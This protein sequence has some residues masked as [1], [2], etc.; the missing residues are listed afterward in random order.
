MTD[1]DPLWYKD[2][3]IYQL[4]VRAFQDSR[5]DGVGD[6]PGLTQRLDYLQDLGVTAVWLLPFYPSPLRDDGYDIAD[7]MAVHPSYGNLPEFQTF[8]DAAHKRGLRVITELVINHTSDQHPWFQRA[9]QAP[10]GSP[11]RNFYVWSDTPDKYQNV[12]LMFPDF[13]TSNWQ[14]DPVAKQYYWHRFYSHQPDLNFDNPAVRAALFPVIDFWMGMGVDGMRLDAVPYLFEREGTLCEHLPET[15]AYL[16]SL[17]KYVDE[18]YPGRMFLAEANAWPED[19]VQ[20][21]GDGDECHMAFNFPL[22][23]R[24]YMALHQEDR[25]PILDVMEQTPPIPDVAQWCLFLRNHD[26]MTLAMI[27]DEERDSMFRAYARDGRAKIFQGIRHRLAPLLGNDRRRIELLTALL[28]S[29]QG[30]PVI[31]YGDEIGMG[32]NIYLGDRNGVRTPMQWSPDRNAGFSRANP[33]RL[34]LPIVIDPEYSYEAVNVETQQANA[35]SLLWWTKRLIALRK[36]Y[37]AFGRGSIEF[38]KPRNPKILAFVR[39]HEDE[40]ILVVANLSRFVQYVELDLKEFDGQV[41]TELTGRTPFPPVGD[42]P[43]LLTVGPHGILWFAVDPNVVR[44]PAVAGR[45]RAEPVPVVPVREGWA[46]LLDPTRLDWLARAVRGYLTETVVAYGQVRRVQDVTIRAAARV[47]IDDAT[48]FLL[49]D[50]AFL[51]GETQLRA[52]RLRYASPAEDDDIPAGAVVAE[53]TRG[54]ERAGLLYDGRTDPG[55]SEAILRGIADGR[56]FR[57]DGHQV[58]AEHFPRFAEVRGPDAVPGPITFRRGDQHDATALFGDRLVLKSYERLEP[59][60]HPAVEVGRF[61]AEHTPFRNTPPVVGAVELRPAEAAESTTMAVLFGHVSNEGTAWRHALDVLSRFYEAVLAHP[62]KPPA[63]APADAW[64][65]GVNYDPH[66]E[67]YDL[68]N[69]Y[70]PAAERIGHVTAELHRALLSAADPPLAPEPFG[71]QYQRSVYQGMRNRVGVTFRGLAQH[72]PELPAETR[73]LA[74]RVLG[75][76]QTLTHRHRLVLSSEVGGI[77]IR[78]H[79]NYHLGELLHTGSDFVVTDF[80]GDPD[81]P[82]TERRI[83]RSPLRDVADMVRSFHYAALSPLYGAESGKGTLPGR[84]RGEDRAE[85][86]GWARFWATWVAARYVRTYFEAVAGTELVPGSPG[87]CREL[88]ELFVLDRTV[89]ELGRELEHRPDWVP[90]P[91]TGLVDMIS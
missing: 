22:M 74:E 89:T 5:N 63:P 15:H 62:L 41:L 14:W 23:P 57:L 21:F 25:F 60:T 49:A 12:P 13:E 76:E 11:E 42:L 86:F 80:E 75:L 61:L 53:L 26:E 52:I 84:V 48:A 66:P 35:S 8:L 77:R 19:M 6:F 58:V 39:R 55:F 17:R 64:T 30:T 59:G 34:Y 91:L 16:K 65:P 24:M 10:K 9:R 43:Y 3:I 40:T 47:P 7:Y 81:R 90:V 4:H 68:L 20:Y 51:D 79:G 56:T 28:F 44:V 71:K 67:F 38:L 50:V 70:L 37:R 54:G 27:T 78:T 46:E 87:V 82:L 2:A 18:K 69:T 88:L 29:L 31:Y 1:N 33:Q 72:L 73:G 85:L 83:K 36:E 32:D 45:P